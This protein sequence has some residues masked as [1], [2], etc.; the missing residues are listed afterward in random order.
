MSEPE[1]VRQA[2]EHIVSLHISDWGWGPLDGI[3]GLTEHELAVVA[4]MAGIRFGRTIQAEI[5]Q[6]NVACPSLSSPST[7]GRRLSGGEG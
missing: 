5:D 2:A 3:E 1:T 7:I 6:L 4:C